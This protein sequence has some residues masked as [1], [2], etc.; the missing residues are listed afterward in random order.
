MRGAGLFPE[1]GLLGP[2]RVAARAHRDPD[3]DADR[4]RVAAGG[5]GHRAQP[6]ED[7]ERLLAWGI[8]IRHPAV[9]DFRGALE[10]ALVMAAEP[11]R[12]PAAFRPRV[13][14][15]VIDRVPAS[16]VGDV[17]LGP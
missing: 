9:A 10:G 6:G 11:P 16:L 15:G 7:V 3:L 14:A 4:A 12:P 13:D 2:I 5:F 1:A 8:G 17:R